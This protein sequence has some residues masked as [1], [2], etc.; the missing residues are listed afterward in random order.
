MFVPDAGDCP[1]SIWTDGWPDAGGDAETIG[2][3]VPVPLLVDVTAAD[4][5][6]WVDI[7]EIFDADGSDLAPLLT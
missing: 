4:A 1:F 5:V 7:W 2:A 3:G 6:C